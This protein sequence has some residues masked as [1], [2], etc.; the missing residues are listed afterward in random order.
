M[1][2]LNA[3]PLAVS[4]DHCMTRSQISPAKEIQDQQI[5]ALCRQLS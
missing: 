1:D 2:L 3:D 5:S 4:V